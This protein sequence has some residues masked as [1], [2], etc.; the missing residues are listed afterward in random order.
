MR[1]PEGRGRR[2][3]TPGALDVRPRRLE[4]FGVV[5]PRWASRLAGQAAEAVA[6]LVGE[7]RASTASSPSAI[8]RMSEMRPRGL[9]RS[10]LVVS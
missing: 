8:A 10:R 7:R 1:S 4:E 9:F 5:D 6:H 3:F 2:A